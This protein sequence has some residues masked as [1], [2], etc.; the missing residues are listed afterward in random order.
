M[1]HLIHKLLLICLFAC[2]GQA[3]SA[4]AFEVDGIYYNITSSTYKTVEVT[5]KSKK[6]DTYYNPAS[7]DI[8]IPSEVMYGGV[9][10]KVSAIGFEAFSGCTGMT[11]IV[12]PNTVTELGSFAF[13]GCTSLT[14]VIIP[15]S[16]K[17]LGTCYTF[18]GCTSLKSVIIP[19]SVTEIPSD[20]FE[21]CTS[22]TS[23]TIP[24]TVTI[25]RHNAFNGCTSLTS[26]VIP[27]SI[28]EIEWRAFYGCTSL[29]SIT[30]PQNF[31]SIETEAFDNTG[32]YNE[33]ADGVLYLNN[34]VI[35]Y[36]GEMPNDADIIIN[37]GATAIASG[38]FQGCTNLTSITIPNSITKI[39]RY[40]FS[41]CTNLWAFG[42][43]SASYSTV[44]L[45][46]VNAW[47]FK[48][49]SCGLGKS[50]DG[51]HV[52]DKNY[53]SE[54]EIYEGGEIIRGVHSGAKHYYYPIMVL[55][56]GTFSIL[57]GSCITIETK[58]ITASL[59]VTCISPTSISGNVTYEK[60]DAVE[61][62]EE[63]V[64]DLN[65]TMKG[66]KFMATGLEPNTEYTFK[67]FLDLYYNGIKTG[68]IRSDSKVVTT[69]ALELTTLKPKVVNSTCAIAAAT[70][71]ISEEETN[72]GFQWKKYEAPESLDPNEGYSR[73][74]DGQIEGYIKNLQGTYYN[75]RAFYKSADETYYYGDWVTF[76]QTDFSYF[77]PTVHTYEATDVTHNSAKVKGYVMQGTDEVTEQGFE[78]WV[79][80]NASSARKVRAMMGAA[81]ADV[82]TV[83]A[84]GQVMTA[85]LDG[86]QPCT[87]Y[88]CR[89][90]VTTTGGTT[91]GEEQT[92]TTTEDATGIYDVQTETTEPTIIGY[93]DLQGRKLNSAVKGVN[94]IRYS[95]GT[96]R[97]VYVK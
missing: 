68:R 54:I 62:I 10:Y 73:I 95:D 71:N 11:S 53:T 15:E 74:Y 78:Y 12:I 65:A 18:G 17:E 52:Y 38:S 64:S 21:S 67:G 19:N 41:G 56:N 36:K 58:K 5:Y 51:V 90:F 26:I 43:S 37:N 88:T 81:S 29:T 83:L 96:A 44:T 59:N 46:K 48:G 85:T 22:L 93:Y 47:G 75:V 4:Y 30:I 86:L 28:A 3:A 45:P 66:N 1:K 35:G 80:G 42:E 91:Y 92:F 34:V 25:I 27:N 40:A 9:V 20:C 84:T 63:G 13:H 49:V 82:T 72:V 60:G 24:N 2:I 94:I 57:D 6:T 70:T 87:T 39:G 79:C 61:T 55:P 7:G 50:N 31:V 8:T 14:S 69:S 32:W 97:K 77:E 76:D 16:V 89:A 33:Q 23:I